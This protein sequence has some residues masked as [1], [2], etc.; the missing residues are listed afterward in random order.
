MK[1]EFFSKDN[2]LDNKA[3]DGGVYQIDL[4]SN[5]SDK[6]IHLYV[7]EAGCIAK[8]CSVHLMKLSDDANYFGLDDNDIADD[9]IILKFSIAKHITK[10]KCG[11]VDPFYIENENKVKIKLKPLTQVSSENSDNMLGK[12][13]RISIVQSKMKE[14]GFK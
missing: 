6:I 13:K 9:S 10:L 14:Y 12:M 8:R 4:L 2:Y 11:R 3:L 5:K 1:I 7:G